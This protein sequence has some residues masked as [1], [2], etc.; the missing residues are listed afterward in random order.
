MEELHYSLV[1]RWVK[2]FLELV[3]RNPR[4]SGVLPMTLM[5][6]QFEGELMKTGFFER[7]LANDKCFKKKLKKFSKRDEL[8]KMLHAAYHPRILYRVC[9]ELGFTRG[10]SL[11]RDF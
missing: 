4:Y 6:H 1:N 10:L 11:I 5:F 9:D 8:S 2:D 7:E 3:D